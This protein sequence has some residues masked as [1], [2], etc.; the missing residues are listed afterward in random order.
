MPLLQILSPLFKN[1]DLFILQLIICTFSQ[2]CLTQEKHDSMARERINIVISTKSR[3]IDPAA[4]S[5]QLQAHFNRVFNGRRYHFLIVAS[6]EEATEKIEKIAGKQNAMIGNLWFDSHGH[7]GR[8]VSMIEVG[9]TEINFN[10]IQDSPI[11]IF[12]KRIGEF[13]DVETIVGLGSCYSGATFLVPAF[14][15]FPEQRM[16]GDSLMIC[17]SNLMNCATVL[18]TESWVMTKPGIFRKTFA[19]SGS[20][21]KKRFQDTDLRYAWKNLGEWVS[22]SSLDGKFNRIHSI[23]LDRNANIVLNHY[24]YL[25]SETHHKRQMKYIAKLKKGNFETKYFYQYE[26][27]IN[28]LMEHTANKKNRKQNAGKVYGE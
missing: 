5:F 11:S 15:R 23:S 19:L 3:Q 25:A 8:R 13:C 14:E 9:K 10:T 28:S 21:L 27:P 16:N 4:Y 7:Y 26:F 20:P 2:H 17:M 18:G 1:K 12:I 24:S 22:Y 6:L